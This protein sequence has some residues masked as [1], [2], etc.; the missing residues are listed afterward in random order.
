[1]SQPDPPQQIPTTKDDVAKTFLQIAGEKLPAPMLL[2]LLIIFLLVVWGVAIEGNLFFLL[3][4]LPV[5]G[6]GAWVWLEW[7]KIKLEYRRIEIDQP[8]PEPQP[9]PAE[10]QPPQP[11]LPDPPQL[12]TEAILKRRYLT[13]L[14]GRCELLPMEAID[15]SAAHTDGAKVA[16]NKVFTQVDALK[17]LPPMTQEQMARM[18]DREGKA[19]R[20]EAALAIIGGREHHYLVLLGKPGSGKTTLVDYIAL[21]LAGHYLARPGDATLDNLER[22]GWRLG[23]LLPARVILRDYAERGLRQK[24]PL[25]EF[26]AAE[27]GRGETQLAPYAPHLRQQWLDEGGLLLLDGLDEVPD[28]HKWREQLRQEILTFAA[29]FKKVR[30]LVTGRPYAYDKPEWQLDAFTRTDLLDFDQAQMFA[31]IDRRYA[32][33]AGGQAGLAE[34]EAQRYA[35]ELKQQIKEREALQ[36]LAARPLLLALITSLHHWRGGRT[37]PQDREKLYDESV[38]L[39]IDLWQQRKRLPEIDPNDK[40]ARELTYLLGVG[41]VELRDALSQVAF[42][43]HRDQPKRQGTA[44]VPAGKLAE[45]LYTVLAPESKVST[46]QIIAYIQNRAGLLEER[47]GTVQGKEIY[48]F[49]HR[50]FQEYLAGCYL[51]TQENFAD[52]AAGLARPDPE[53]WREALLLAVRR[54]K[55]PGPAWD[56]IDALCQPPEPPRPGA[57][58]PEAAWWGAFL[59]GQVLLEREL[60]LSPPERRQPLVNR[61]I[62]WLAALLAAGALPQRDRAAAGRMLAQLGDPRPGVGVKDGV[63]DIAWGETVPAGTYRLGGDQGAYDAK[64]KEVNIK[65]P[66]QLARY[67]ITN[68]QFQAF[69]DA[70]D[71][72]DPRWWAGLPEKEKQFSQPGFPYANHPR[73]TVSW[74]QSIAFCRWLSDK[75]GYE[76]DLPHEDEWE[77][78]ARYPNNWFYP[79]GNEFDPEKANTIEGGLNSSTAVGSYPQ[80]ANAALGLYD[81]SGN[82]CEWS[83]NKYDNPEDTKVDDSPARRVVRGGSWGFDLIFA[84]AASRDHFHPDIRL[85]DLGARVVRRSP[86]P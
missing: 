41:P 75:L 20:R 38:D 40:T 28:A 44:D 58:T 35:Q 34:G 5:L 78:A 22:Q 43:V 67:P 62:G 10:P 53:R 68:A 29:T 64:P 45:A 7:Q 83:R 8:K 36:N 50:T 84:R 63:P 3:L 32:L 2:V 6:V 17:P 51:L 56:L 30:I 16:L 24:R 23:W 31:Y 49:V 77:A 82:V 76:V 52:A 48:A 9:S 14:A 74:Y 57:A 25:W 13:W 59:A 73:E 60:W 26:I 42:E 66:Y 19:N 15:K 11:L 86:S 69:I 33:M 1:M 70:A 27:L 65:Q 47:D 37:L 81:L 12:E 61:V 4:L 39:L 54:D 46:R 85:N 80:G 72:A 79:W 55:N 18:S 71:V 21:C